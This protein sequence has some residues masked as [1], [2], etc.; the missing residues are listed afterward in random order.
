MP[1]QS[2]AANRLVQRHFTHEQAHRIRRTAAQTQGRRFA[3]RG[4]V[5]RRCDGS[6]RIRPRGRIGKR[7]Q[8]RRVERGEWSGNAVCG[9][10]DF[11]DTRACGRAEAEHVAIGDELRH[12]HRSHRMA[13]GGDVQAARGS[14]ARAFHAEIPYQ[15]VGS[16][17]LQPAD[18]LHFGDGQR[19][20]TCRGNAS[21][22]H[23]C[24]SRDRC[25]KR[26]RYREVP[27]CP[28]LDARSAASARKQRNHWQP[29][30]HGRQRFRASSFSLRSLGSLGHTASAFASTSLASAMRFS[31]K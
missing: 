19:L 21:G 13:G 5:R 10:D 8:G 11:L 16:H 6:Q 12:R 2:H 25:R 15:C 1:L 18:Q 14:L 26:N 7:R 31:S 4:R 27:R 29:C 28:R 9:D 20:A 24:T 23:I 22:Q 30:R 17:D 3:H